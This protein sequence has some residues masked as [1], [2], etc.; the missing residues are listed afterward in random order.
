MFSARVAPAST[1]MMTARLRDGSSR[2]EVETS[3]RGIGMSQPGAKTTP[4][5]SGRY[6]CEAAGD[7]WLS[8]WDRP[9]GERHREMRHADMKV[10]RP[11]RTIP[12]TLSRPNFMHASKL[13]H[14]PFVGALVTDRELQNWSSY[15][16]LVDSSA[17]RQPPSLA[18]RA[19][20][21]GARY[22]QISLTSDELFY[23][24][25]AVAPAR[26]YPTTSRGS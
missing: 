5:R 7:R 17:P 10:Y 9:S 20:A 21:Y 26:G 23:G 6:R 16:W 2:K 11:R 8:S 13:R 3:W 24:V 1:I 15:Y 14:T 22:Y 18:R 4:M 12:G 25:G 19:A